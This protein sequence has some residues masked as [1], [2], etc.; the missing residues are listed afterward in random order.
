MNPKPLI[1]LAL[2]ASLL[3]SLPA[4]AQ[5]YKWVDKDG[6]IHYSDK[7]PRDPKAKGVKDMHIESK[8]TDPEAVARDLAELEARGKS[9]DQ[10]LA[11]KQQVAAQTATEKA[12]AEKMCDQAMARLAAL[13]QVQRMAKVDKDGNRS[14]ASDGETNAEREKSRKQVDELCK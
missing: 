11:V 14:Y 2:L 12:N 1:A 5:V 13:E 10:N 8:P 3:F 9:V 7:P 4:T 6:K